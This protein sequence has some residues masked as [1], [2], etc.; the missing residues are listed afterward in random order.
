MADNGEIETLV[1]ETNRLTLTDDTARETTKALAYFKTN[2]HR[3]RYAYRLTLSGMRQNIPGATGILHPA[4]P[5]S[6]ALPMC[7]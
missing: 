1:T 4:L 3:M 7:G 2:A 5:T 6:Q